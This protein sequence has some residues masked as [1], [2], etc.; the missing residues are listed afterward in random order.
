V[1]TVLPLLHPEKVYPPDGTVPAVCVNVGV[2]PV[3]MASL[4]V[5][6][7]FWLIGTLVALFTGV[8]AVTV[9]GVVSTS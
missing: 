1:A 4:N 2:V 6:I 8:V 5:I 3:P 7:T 9:G